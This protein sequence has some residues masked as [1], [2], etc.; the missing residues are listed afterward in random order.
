MRFDKLSANGPIAWL[1]ICMTERALLILA[2]RAMLAVAALA[3]LVL[4]WRY[5]AGPAQPHGAPSVRV[6]K[7]LP[8]T[9]LWADAPADPRYLPP[10]LGAPDAER[11]KLLLLRDEQGALRA[12]WLPRQQG[13]PGLP[14]GASPDGPAIP[15]RDIAPDF[16]QGDIA[17]RQ[18]QPGFE[19]ALRHRWA[20][21][22]QPLTSGT[23][24]LAAAP[25]QERD[26]D[27]VMQARPR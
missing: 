3:A 2:L 9:F 8:G 25:G 7:L 21:D 11:L 22:G 14:S 5:A 26:G 27:W 6:L 23:P 19:F 10:G 16:R 12:F 18:A 17:C 1:E 15:C 4:S 20:L 24:P 13:Q